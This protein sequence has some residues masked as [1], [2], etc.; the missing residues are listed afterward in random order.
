MLII[1]YFICK[2]IFGFDNVFEI[3]KKAEGYELVKTRILI[4][5]IREFNEFMLFFAIIVS[6]SMHF[7]YHIWEIDMLQW[8]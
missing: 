6:L 4:S 2:I 5:Y 7:F 3:I 1:C 8:F